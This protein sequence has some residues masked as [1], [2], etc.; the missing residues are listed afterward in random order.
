MGTAT[1]EVSGADAAFWAAELHAA[2]AASVA[3]GESVSPVEVQR[4]AE[5]VIA[6]IGLVFAGVGTAKT[7]WDWWQARRPQGVTVTVLFDDGTQVEVSAAGRAELEIT[8]QRA[9]SRG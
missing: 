1:V 4:S 9:A 7:M 3:P 2:L 8:F 6:V 5:L